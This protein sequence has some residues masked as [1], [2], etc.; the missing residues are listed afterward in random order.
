MHRDPC[1]D[2]VGRNQDR[3]VV[4]GTGERDDLVAERSRPEGDRTIDVFGTQHDRSEPQHGESL[5]PPSAPMDERKTSG[6]A[7]RSAAEVN[8]P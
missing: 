8:A 6:L 4:I 1:S 2:A 5:A 7:Q 3:E